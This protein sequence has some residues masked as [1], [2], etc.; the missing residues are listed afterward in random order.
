MSEAKDRL[1]K[2]ARWQTNRMNLGWYEKILMVERVRD[3]IESLRRSS[4][5]QPP[6]GAAQEDK[7]APCDPR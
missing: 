5:P 7:D 2:Q 3:S 1:D 6:H 4:V